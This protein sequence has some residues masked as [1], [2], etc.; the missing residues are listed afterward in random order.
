M[1]DKIRCQKIPLLLTQIKSV[2]EEALEDLTKA[3]IVVDTQTEMKGAI[4]VEA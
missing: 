1:K 3:M 4:D 2:S